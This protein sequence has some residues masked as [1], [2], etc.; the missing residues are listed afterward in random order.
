MGGQSSTLAGPGFCDREKE[1]VQWFDLQNVGGV[2]TSCDVTDEW[3]LKRRAE[4][5]R[6]I[7]SAENELCSGGAA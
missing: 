2:R 7:V 6:K 1:E 5:N 4:E 3:V